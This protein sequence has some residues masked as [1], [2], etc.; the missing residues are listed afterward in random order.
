MVVAL[1]GATIYAGAGAV[2]GSMNAGWFGLERNTNSLLPV[3]GIGAL[4]IVGGFASTR[5][6]SQLRAAGRLGRVTC[7]LLIVGPLFYILS[8]LVE[9]AILGTLTLGIALICLSVSV[10]RGQ[11]VPA[12]DRIMIILSAIGSLTWNTETVSAFLL[13]GVGLLWIVLSIRLLEDSS[14]ATRQGTSV[15]DQFC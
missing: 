12:L 5:L 3:L 9:F 8:W 2:I 11:M 14:R 13:V 1:L 10:T 15:P 7:V 4:L 6:N